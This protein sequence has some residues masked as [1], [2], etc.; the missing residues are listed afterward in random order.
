MKI[1]HQIMNV[2]HDFSNIFH[3]SCMDDPTRCHKYKS[4]SAAMTYYRMLN[5][6]HVHAG[7]MHDT[8]ED[9]PLCR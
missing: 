1:R 3:I 7:V 9:V 8:T 2:E 4:K 5:V 6:F